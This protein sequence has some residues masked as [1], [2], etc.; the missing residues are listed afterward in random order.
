MT[1][2]HIFRLHR[3][4]GYSLT[5]TLPREWILGNSLKNSD[6]VIVEQNGAELVI[7]KR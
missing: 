1:K 7:R 4:G 5:V 6:E 2:Q 3:T